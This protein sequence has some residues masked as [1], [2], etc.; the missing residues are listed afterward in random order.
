MI[1]NMIMGYLGAFQTQYDETAEDMGGSAE[2]YDNDPT[3]SGST[4]SDGNDSGSGTDLPD[5]FNSV[6]C[7]L[8]PDGIVE[9]MDPQECINS[10]IMN[11]HHQS[12]NIT[13]TQ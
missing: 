8:P 9:Q 12:Q 1:W 7:T 4:D 6:D 3:N 13:R 2:E 10:K 5:D 11:G